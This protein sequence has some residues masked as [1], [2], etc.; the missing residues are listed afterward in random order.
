MAAGPDSEMGSA[1]RKSQSGP[2]ES[3]SELAL[4]HVH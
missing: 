1:A 2:T 3:E 4:S